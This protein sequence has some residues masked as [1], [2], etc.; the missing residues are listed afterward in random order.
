MEA[1]TKLIDLLLE[2]KDYLK[3]WAAVRAWENGVI[4]RYGRANRVLEAGYY[5]KWPFAEKLIRVETAIAT[6]QLP[7]QTVGTDTVRGVVKYRIRDAKAYVT[8]ILGDAA[9]L[10]DITMRHV[11][12]WIVRRDVHEPLLAEKIQRSAREEAR[13]YGFEIVTFDFV[14][15]STMRAYRLMMDAGEA[16]DE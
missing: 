16:L 4:L 15:I 12:R 7:P 2:A 8:E 3:P 9:F 6:I 5:W 10:R 13:T 11:K 14:E 1:I